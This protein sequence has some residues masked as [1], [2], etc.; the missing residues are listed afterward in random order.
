MCLGPVWRRWTDAAL[1]LT[2]G[3]TACGAPAADLASRVRSPQRKVV[4]GNPP[5]GPALPVAAGET[6]TAIAPQPLTRKAETGRVRGAIWVPLA[7]L[8]GISLDPVQATPT[9]R[10]GA[11]VVGQNGGSVVGQNGGSVVGQNGGSVVGQNGGSV[12]GQNG[13]SV[14]GQNGGSVVR[15][16]GGSV[17]GQNGGSVVG[18][19]GGSLAR[20]ASARLGNVSLR[21]VDAALQPV[22][23]GAGLP[24]T[25][26]SG[27]EGQFELTVPA[28][29]QQALIAI[30]A[31]AWGGPLLALLPQGPDAVSRLVTVDLFSTMTLSRVLRQ[32][33]QGRQEVLERLTP[34]LTDEAQREL[35]I[36]LG[37]DLPSAAPDLAGDRLDTLLAQAQAKRPELAA[38]HARIAALLT[39][40]GV[41]REGH[42]R[43]ASELVLGE[44]AGVA[45]QG[46]DSWI[47]SETKHV[48]WR[49]GAD[50]RVETV[51]PSGAWGYAERRDPPTDAPAVH[52]GMVAGAA[53]VVLADSRHDRVVEAGPT[54]V[55]VLAGGGE[56]SLPAAGDWAT[57][58]RLNTPTGLADLG[59]GRLAIAES[60]ADRVLVREA[61]GRLRVLVGGGPNVDAGAPTDPLQVAL[62]SPQGLA[63]IGE[64][65]WICDRGHDRLRRLDLAR[66]TLQDVPASPALRAPMALGPDGDGV[67]VLEHL[68]G[69]L[70]FWDRGTV[71]PWALPAGHLGSLHQPVALAWAQG[72][73]L[74]ARPRGPVFALDR[75]ADQ[76]TWLAGTAPG[77]HGRGFVGA[78]RFVR[79]PDGRLVVADFTQRRLYAIAPDGATEPLVGS[80][81]DGFLLRGLPPLQT[82]MGNPTALAIAPDGSLVFAVTGEAPCLKRLDASGTLTTIAG[83]GRSGY[84]RV[85]YGPALGASLA[86]PRELAFWPDG[87]LAIIEPGPDRI[88]QLDARGELQAAAEWADLRAPRAFAPGP[89][90]SW[91]CLE[92]GTARVLRLRGREREV[93]LG[94]AELASHVA[95][96]DLRALAW[97]PDEALWLGGDRRV[98][99]KP[100]GGALQLVAGPGAPLLAGALRDDTLQDVR[101][102]LFD[103]AGDLYIL[104][105]DQVKR[106]PR[107]LWQ[108]LASPTR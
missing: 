14:V 100:A 97:G 84:E 87:R 23:D 86:N 5:S 96:S 107:A 13:G 74:L 37:P 42:G 32:H 17:V 95:M 66:G 103:P 58:V 26:V 27:D 54:G 20:F 28:G 71:T 4:R 44:V 15:Q 19:N 10:Q 80:G 34:A 31:P 50:Q 70:V 7:W 62:K 16:N 81:S 78:T 8:G 38:V 106:L 75:A 57:Q 88:V 46:P 47:F 91:L 18:Q 65:L 104:E 108:P 21:L 79:M 73:G 30:D 82:P 59:E 35:A 24:I 98:W 36:A 33:V 83:D 48:L 64:A 76:L 2:C 3:L 12:V 67:C 25:A 101:D 55:R 61:D 56:Q 93:L 22:R 90:G 43:P 99:R 52:S 85:P 6:A 60:G 72:R 89:E 41:T 9:V 45:T 102:M 92:A 94:E 68:P 77:R 69:G 53:R 1:L 39:F 29:L 105:L 51:V 49:I 63:R 40:A 11:R